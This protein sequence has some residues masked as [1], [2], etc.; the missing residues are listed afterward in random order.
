[1]KYYLLFFCLAYFAVTFLLPSWRVWKRTGINPFVVPRDDSAYGFIGKVFK[2]LTAL[3]LATVSLHAFAERWDKFLLPAEY[4]EQP[5]IRW[6]GLLLLHGSLLL[7]VV[8][9]AQMRQSWR[10]G[11]DEK[12][13]TALV[14]SGLFGHSRNPIF[15]GMLLTMLGLFLVLPNAATLLILALSWAVLQIQVRLEEAFLEKTHGQGYVD[16]S[17]ETRRWI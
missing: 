4:L 3:V 9:Q 16:Y 8:A 10:I 15:L 13:E 12:N 11:I 1:M 17:Q 2:L 14:V 6:A 7:I 5:G